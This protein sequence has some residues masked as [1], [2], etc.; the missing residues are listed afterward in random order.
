MSLRLDR[1]RRAGRFLE[2]KVGLFSVGA[3]LGLAGMFLQEAWMVLAAIGVLLS[4]MLLRFLPSP[5][6]GTPPEGD[7]DPPPVEDEGEGEGKG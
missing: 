1:T 7:D 2:W 3:V 6:S 4:A 5:R